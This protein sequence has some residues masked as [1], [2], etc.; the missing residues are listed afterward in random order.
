MGGVQGWEVCRDERCA[1]MG[2]GRCAEMGEDG[3]VYRD[4][5]GVQGW[6]RDGEVCRDGSLIPT[7]RS[8]PLLPT[9]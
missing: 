3:D 8:S 5:G 4:G 6:G 9:F 7:L 2:W 1:A